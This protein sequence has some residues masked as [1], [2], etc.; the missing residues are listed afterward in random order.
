MLSKGWEYVGDGIDGERGTGEESCSA[1]QA[2][3][4]RSCSA[5]SND[6]TLLGRGHNEAV[7]LWRSRV[8]LCR[9]HRAIAY[10]SS[11]RVG[12]RV[13]KLTHKRSTASLEDKFTNVHVFFKIPRKCVKHE[14]TQ[15][16][17]RKYRREANIIS[18]PI[19]ELDMK[20]WLAIEFPLPGQV[21]CNGP[22]IVV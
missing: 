17:S 8:G 13:K 1:W 9:V 2:M 14:N 20:R 3:H 19:P 15:S 6:I 10:I 22:F 16:L 12:P 7:L 11:L 21:H 4:P 18:A 5:E